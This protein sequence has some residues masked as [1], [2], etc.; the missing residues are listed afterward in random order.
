VDLPGGPLAVTVDG[1]PR[2]KVDLGRVQIAGDATHVFDGDI[3]VA[4]TELRS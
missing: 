4:G 2:A 3:D 1:D